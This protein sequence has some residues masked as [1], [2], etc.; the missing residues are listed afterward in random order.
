MSLICVLTSASHGPCGSAGAEANGRAVPGAGD[1]QPVTRVRYAW[2][3]SPVVNL[4]DDAALP[5]GPF[6]IAL[7]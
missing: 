3:D 4:F 1:G 5:L 2:A 6:E 7:P